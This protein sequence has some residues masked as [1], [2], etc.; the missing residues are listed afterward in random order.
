MIHLAAARVVYR[1]R[2]GAVDAARK[3]RR[4]DGAG[5]GE[6]IIKPAGLGAGCFL[7]PNE[8][9][10]RFCFSRRQTRMARSVPG[11]PRSLESLEDDMRTLFT[12]AV[13]LEKGWMPN[14]RPASD[15]R[16]GIENPANEM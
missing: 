10:E 16:S 2:E 4:A 9:Q 15:A 11:R 6:R 3:M 7:A 1:L 13:K 12:M 14:L 8:H 5:V